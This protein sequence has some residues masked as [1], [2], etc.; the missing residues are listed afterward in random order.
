VAMGSRTSVGVATRTSRRPALGASRS[1]DY[2]RLQ[3]LGTVHPTV[4]KHSSHWIRRAAVVAVCGALVVGAGWWWHQSPSLGIA[5]LD[6][7][8]SISSANLTD[9]PFEIEASGLGGDIRLTVDGKPAQITEVGDT[10]AWDAP[11]LAEGKH[12]VTLSAARRL[13]GSTSTTIEF[14]V[15]NTPPKVTFDRAEKPAVDAPYTVAG[16]TE[17][18]AALQIGEKSSTADGDGRFE[19]EFDHPP[20]AALT[21][22]DPAGNV[23]RTFVR[24]DVAHPGATAVHVTSDAWGDPERKARILALIEG[25]NI[26]TVQLDLKDE[27]GAVG[28]DSD[29][30]LANEIGAVR[31]HYV[32]AEALDE[33]H[34]L[35]VRVVGRIVAFRDPTLAEAAWQRGDRDWVLQS[36]DGQ[37]FPAYGGGFVNY[38]NRHVRRY[39]LDIAAEAARAGIDE[40]MWD[41]MR[42]P[43][44]SPESMVV[45]GR[46]DKPSSEYITSFLAA[47]RSRLRSLGV[48]QS[49]AVFGIAIDRGDSIAQ[50][51]PAMA[52]HLDAINP[53]V[54]PSHWNEGEYGVGNPDRQPY[55]IVKA[56]VGPFTEV[57]GGSGPPVI[58]WVQDFD[59]SMPY[60]PFEV[61]TQIAAAKDAGAIGAFIW[62]P[63]SDYSIDGITPTLGE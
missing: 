52:R 2:G 43:E 57:L 4:G 33:L 39:N 12:T 34:G 14:E 46:G 49:A 41:Y 45:P 55:D 6:D 58:P 28:Y 59:S 9:A 47:G 8:T 36:P 15:D 30:P 17:P 24:T 42:R 56:S 7:G 44:G 35:G 62:N 5:G 10:L 32:L 20:I 54:Y 48:L 29:V 1:I 26:D 37:R 21:A 31:N 22:T 27:A 40:I 11:E 61:A 38:V 13:V 25:G 63:D 60:G 16:R 50:D 18:G 23:A 53:M 3:R 19:I 51:I